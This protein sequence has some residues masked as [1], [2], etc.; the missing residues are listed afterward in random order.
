MHSICAMVVL[1]NTPLDIKDAFAV[2]KIEA[3]RKSRIF[4]SCQHQFPTT[5]RAVDFA[6]VLSTDVVT[7]VVIS[8]V[9]IQWWCPLTWS[10]SRAV[11]FRVVRCSTYCM[12]LAT[13]AVQY[14]NQLRTCT[15]RKPLNRKINFNEKRKTAFYAV[16][17]ITAILLLNRSQHITVFVQPSVILACLE[18]A[19]AART[20]DSSA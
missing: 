16:Y 6:T 7:L 13:I 15:L 8:L 19:I 12:F 5:L 3:N 9:V 11:L 2:G 20:G 14:S 18:V 1:P 4:K 17:K 10:V